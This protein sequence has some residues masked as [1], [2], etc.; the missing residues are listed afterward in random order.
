M[1]KPGSRAA[2]PEIIDS[3][4][5]K[6]RFRIL[7]ES[8]LTLAFWTGFLY[9]LTPLLTLLL[10]AFGVRI[11]YT[12][13]L[14]AQ[15]FIE[16]IKIFKSGFYTV[17][18]VG[19]LIMGWGYYNY[20]MFRIKGERRNSQVKICFDQD[21]SARFQIDL[22]TLQA[23]KEQSCLSVTLTEGGMEVKP[24]PALASPTVTQPP[25]KWKIKLKKRRHLTGSSCPKDISNLRDN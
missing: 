13:L 4:R 9:L 22:Q 2:N 16:L 25:R 14:G 17:V 23:A 18:T 12:E 15:G 1:E 24:A 20:L 7:L 8:F 19:V 3:W 6:S 10:W 5:L 21:F 11:A